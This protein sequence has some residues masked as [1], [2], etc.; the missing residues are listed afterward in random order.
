MAERSSRSPLQ[1]FDPT[2][3]SINDQLS[4]V[5]D[6]LD[7]LHDSV[8]TLE[9]PGEDTDPTTGAPLP[10]DTTSGDFV[11]TG[12]VFPYVGAVAPDGYLLCDG[13]AVS[14]A[15][16]AT[17]FGVIGTSYGV[18]DG[19]TTFNVPDLRGRVAV[20]KDAATFPTLGGTG[21][22]ET[23]SLPS[24]TH[25]L[26]A[27]VALSETGIGTKATTTGGPSAASV[28]ILQPYQVFNMIVKT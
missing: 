19:T 20:G 15:T 27:G 7:A 12:V 25:T 26:A 13:S 21:G 17:L 14:R 24:H 11:P 18:G 10:P 3:E 1:V 23:S 9:N 4:K 22:A 16:Y 8:T 28:N 5:R 2:A 6:E